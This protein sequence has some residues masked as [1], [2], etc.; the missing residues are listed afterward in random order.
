MV[1]AW[2]VLDK[3]SSCS[4]QFP[5]SSRCNNSLLLS[6]QLRR[7]EKSFEPSLLNEKKKNSL[8]EKRG[9][10]VKSIDKLASSIAM[11]VINS[12]AMASASTNM[13]P[14]MFM[15]QMQMQMQMQQ[16]LQL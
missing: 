3:Q 6:N 1:T 5:L 8:S 13:M 11:D 15:M 14:M 7:R 12:A 10:I 9:S 2:V 16:Q 4:R